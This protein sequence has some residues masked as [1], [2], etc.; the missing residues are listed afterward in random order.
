MKNLCMAV[1]LSLA[2]LGGGATCPADVTLSY[3]ISDGTNDPTHQRSGTETSPIGTIV[4]GGIEYDF[5]F[6]PVGNNNWNWNVRGSTVSLI[7]YGPQD[8]PTGAK[9]FLSGST[10]DRPFTV[11]YNGPDRRSSDRV[12]ITFGATFSPLAAPL[13]VTAG[14]SGDITSMNPRLTADPSMVATATGSGTFGT[15]DFD[16]TVGPKPEPLA[17]GSLQGVI[18]FTWNRNLQINGDTVTFSQAY[19]AATPVPEPSGFVVAACGSLLGLVAYLLRRRVGGPGPGLE[20]AD[21]FITAVLA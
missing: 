10:S 12:Q 18:N 7:L 8:G 16:S 3:T 21:G 2:I 20:S 4:P 11:R 5:A 1:L 17:V 19:V 14:L 15:V 9:L 6:G 13:V